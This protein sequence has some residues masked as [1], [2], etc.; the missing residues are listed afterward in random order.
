MAKTALQNGA[1]D[2]QETHAPH[3]L[4]DLFKLPRRRGQAARLLL[5]LCRNSKLI[6]K[7]VRGQKCSII[8]RRKVSGHRP[9]WRFSPRTSAA[10]IEAGLKL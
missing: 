10:G 8:T 7:I 1:F 4:A 5:F 2:Q 3:Q 9:D 6:R